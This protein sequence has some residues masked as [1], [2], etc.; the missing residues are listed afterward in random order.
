MSD[1]DKDQENS[2][3]ERPAPHRVIGTP[4]PSRGLLADPGPAGGGDGGG[5]GG[6]RSPAVRE[7]PADPPDPISAKRWE[8]ATAALFMLAAIAGAGFIAAYGGLEV[9]GHGQLG[10]AGAPAA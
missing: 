1:N 6:D 2:P 4:P 9:Q 8:R 7:L 3:E 10:V 5:S